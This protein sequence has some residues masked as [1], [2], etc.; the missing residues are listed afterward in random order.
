MAAPDP[1]QMSYSRQ[2]ERR[3]QVRGLLL[4]ALAIF[5]FSLLRGGVHRIFTPGWWRLW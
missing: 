4:L 1:T 5:L 3:R 2:Q